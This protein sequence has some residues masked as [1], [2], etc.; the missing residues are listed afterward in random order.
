[1]TYFVYIIECADESYYTGVTRNIERRM[2][3]HE[4]RVDP[5]C[6]TARRLPI[7][8]VYSLE[9]EDVNDAI[10]QEKQIKGWTRAKKKA[11]IDGRFEDLRTLAK[12][13]SNLKRTRHPSTSS[14]RQK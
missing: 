4:S 10:A 5:K 11:L 13:K 3:E 7:R 2:F 14:G 8:L 9:H 6:Y 1:M 12:S